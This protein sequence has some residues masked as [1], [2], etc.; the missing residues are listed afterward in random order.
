[1]VPCWGT[2][3]ILLLASSAA[4]S[5]LC[6][7]WDRCWH[8]VCPDSQSTMPRCCL[9]TWGWHTRVTTHTC[10][11][12]SPTSCFDAS[13]MCLLGFRVVREESSAHELPF[14]CLSKEA[15]Q[16][17]RSRKRNW[18]SWG[19]LLIGTQRMD[20][21]CTRAVT[22]SQIHRVRKTSGST[23]VGTCCLIP[24]PVQPHTVLNHRITEWLR[25]EGG[26]SIPTLSQQRHPEQGANQ[27][28]P[29]GFWRS[30]RSRSNNLFEQL[31]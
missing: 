22:Q 21:K 9:F 20:G 18:G 4:P 2:A 13:S 23:T 8:A 7:P 30:P 24:S 25:L 14:N 11:H 6:T 29:G 17:S 12:H 5:P 16:Q 10:G 19:V 1:M 15:L 31:V 3:T 27:L 28:H 26:Q